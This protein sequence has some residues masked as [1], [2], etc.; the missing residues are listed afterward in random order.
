MMVREG[1]RFVVGVRSASEGRNES[2]QDGSTPFQLNR[3]VLHSEI[4]RD[5]V[6]NQATPAPYVRVFSSR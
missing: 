2:R 3:H 1:S 5:P 6:L 4:R